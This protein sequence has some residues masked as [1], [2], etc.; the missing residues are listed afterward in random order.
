MI[1]FENYLRMLNNY[2]EKKLSEIS[3][4]EFL[5]NNN[6]NNSHKHLQNKKVKT[7]TKRSMDLIEENIK[8]FDESLKNK[9]EKSD[10][11][12]N[13]EEEKEKIYNNIRNKIIDENL[14]DKESDDFVEEDDKSI[15][16]DKEE[17]YFKDMIKRNFDS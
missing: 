10:K 3:L 12:K 7:E 11:R 15:T 6:Q 13:S 8:A 5:Y 14:T 1:F 17:N 9:N 4:E 16:F 2:D